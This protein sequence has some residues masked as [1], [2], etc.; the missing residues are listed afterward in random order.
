MVMC[1]SGGSIG[2]KTGA[3]LGFQSRSLK[4]V[5][6]LQQAGVAKVVHV[7]GGLGQW[8]REGL[9]VQGSQVE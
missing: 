2:E 4:A 5:Y 7:E 3:P 6:Y 9:P 8:L 1:E